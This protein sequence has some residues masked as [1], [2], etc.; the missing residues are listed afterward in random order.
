M[1]CE[2][3]RQYFVEQIKKIYQDKCA[4]KNN[5]FFQFSFILEEYCIMHF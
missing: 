5:I 4:K 1:E 2:I 3:S